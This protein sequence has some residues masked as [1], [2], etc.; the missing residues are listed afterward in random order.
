MKFTRVFNTFKYRQF[1]SGNEAGSWNCFGM[2]LCWINGVLS[3][4]RLHPP[5]KLYQFYQASL[6]QNEFN[7][8]SYPYEKLKFAGE[9]LREKQRHMVYDIAGDGVMTHLPIALPPKEC[10]R[11]VY[12]A[13]RVA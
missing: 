8:D 11:H 5:E 6:F 4:G 12:R 7:K 2:S 13:T 3:E 9:A 1:M 10:W